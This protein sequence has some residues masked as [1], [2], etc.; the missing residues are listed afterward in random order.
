M[1]RPVKELAGFKR[2][3]IM[4]GEKVRVRFTVRADL[5][6]FLDRSMRWKVE[7]GDVDVEIGS[8]SADIRL[9]GEYRITEDRWLCGS[10][11]AF[12]AEVQTYHLKDR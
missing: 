1:T 3:H 11:R 10:E 5:T 6:A 2:I 12:C 4:P 9:K 7:S 8:S